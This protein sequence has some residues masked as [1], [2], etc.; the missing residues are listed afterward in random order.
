MALKIGING[1]GRIG[2]NVY[3]VVHK[4]PDIEVVAVNDITDC[5][6][7]A[8]LLKYDSV[9]GVLDADVRADGDNLVVGAKKTRVLAEREPGRLPWKDLG[10]DVVIE[11]TGLFTEADKA[12][13]HIRSG[14][15]KKVIISAP[16]KGEDLTICLGVNDQ[17]YDPLKHHV[18]SNASCT[19]N[20]VAPM[21]KVLNE[22]FGIV[23]GLM[24]TIHAY[25]ADQR[26]Q[27]APH[28]DLRRA[29]AASVSMVPTSTGAAKAVGL[30]L[31]ELKGRLDGLAIRVPVPNVSI[32]DLSCSLE[33][34]TTREEILQAFRAAAQKNPYL[35]VSDEPLVSIDFNGNASSCTLDG[36]SVY[37][38]GGNFAKVLGW[39]DNEIGYSTRLVDLAV[40][41][42]RR[43]F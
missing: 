7:L 37:V 9:H 3:R 8:H 13:E 29:R 28:K 21:A 32:I 38:I 12:S 40:F 10:A 33:R 26:L 4:R 17:K 18:I 6:T 39:Y 16:A 2:R 41:L 34:E 25:T 15:A 11:S 20:C 24:T 1:F 42:H 36:Q 22:S 27:D 5:K 14:G 31:P 30:V 43:G 35:S 19:T 23:K